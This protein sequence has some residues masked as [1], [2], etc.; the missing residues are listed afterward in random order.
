MRKM[1]PTD[2][3]NEY[4]T[5]VFKPTRVALVHIKAGTSSSEPLRFCLIDTCLEKH[6]TALISWLKK[7]TGDLATIDT[8]FLTHC[9]SDH[10]G[11]LAAVVSAVKEAGGDPLV[12]AHSS[13][14]QYI[15][16]GELRVPPGLLLPMKPVMGLL[17]WI[18]RLTSSSIAPVPCTAWD[19][20]RDVLVRRGFDLH[21]LHTPGHTPGSVTLVLGGA[22]FVGDC[23]FNTWWT[24]GT[25]PVGNSMDDIRDS[26]RAILAEGVATIVPSHGR[27]M[28]ASRLKELL[29]D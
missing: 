2:Q 18:S 14:A 10:T 17:A 21:V 15:T 3:E 6:T 20:D 1:K 26:W 5:R 7:S 13:D 9:H 25:P 4:I 19:G 8:I 23:C 16:K 11:A 27:L 28:P 22:A 29:K 24:R 12:I